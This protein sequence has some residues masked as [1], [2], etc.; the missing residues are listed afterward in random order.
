MQESMLSHPPPSQT[1]FLWG[2][3]KLLKKL[4][5]KRRANTTSFRFWGVLSVE[6]PAALTSSVGAL[7][8]L[9]APN[10]P[11]HFCAAAHILATAA[12]R[13]HNLTSWLR[14]GGDR[15]ERRRRRGNNRLS[16]GGRCWQLNWSSRRLGGLDRNNGRR[17]RRWRGV[18]ARR[19][20]WGGGGRAGSA[21]LLYDWGLVGRRRCPRRRGAS[22]KPI[23]YLSLSV[24]IKAA[25]THALA[26]TVFC[27]FFHL[28]HEGNCWVLFSL[29]LEMACFLYPHRALPT[30]TFF[31]RDWA[32]LP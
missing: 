24:I 4:H 32:D 19:V 30:E 7:L 29:A 17:T 8:L 28:C 22:L 18:V 12:W 3:G 27:F 26:T 15:A 14:S 25:A 23:S 9:R 1:K 10:S 5:K 11:I 16:R 2:G 31:C 20:V 6:A 13:A 21:V